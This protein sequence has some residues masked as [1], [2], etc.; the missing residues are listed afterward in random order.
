MTPL[1][2]LAA[3]VASDPFFLAHALSRHA[4]A[5]GLSDEQLAA[6]LRCSPEL[7]THL[8]LCRTPGIDP[9]HTLTDD[10]RAVCERFGCDAAALARIVLA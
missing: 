2:H 1:E 10:L 6:E 9:R 5:R 4:R 8:R 7:L 3:R